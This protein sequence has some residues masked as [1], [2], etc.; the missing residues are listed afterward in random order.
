MVQATPCLTV[1]TA[2]SLPAFSCVFL[3][4]LTAFLL[5]P[6]RLYAQ[7]RGSSSDPHSP[8]PGV[9]SSQRQ[10]PGQPP[11]RR[12]SSEQNGLGQVCGSR[13]AARPR[14][15]TRAVVCTEAERRESP[16]SDSS[17]EEPRLSGSPRQKAESMGETG[18][19]RGFLPQSDQV[20]AQRNGCH[21]RRARRSLGFVVHTVLLVILVFQ[22][23]GRGSGRNSA[24]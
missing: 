2:L 3:L 18:S 8:R 15:L 6:T 13:D 16:S 20:R 21:D 10:V 12:G 14:S 7:E 4:L 23:K 11:G 22:T 9:V 5:S 17:Q 19:A 1:F 24:L